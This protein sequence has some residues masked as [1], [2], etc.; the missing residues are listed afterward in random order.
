MAQG[1]KKKY[2]LKK[3]VGWLHLVLGL[4]SGLIIVLL[5]VTGCILAF[6][7]E[8]RSVTQ[9]A[10]YTTP[11]NQPVLP[12]SVLKANAKKVLDGPLANG[13]ESPGEGKSAVVS[14]YDAD[15]FYRVALDP[16]T[17]AVKEKR[18]MNR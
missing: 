8:I 2:G 15:H 16:Y 11:T 1:A 5:G 4:S 3:I 10:F 9:P 12:P 17:G 13:I 7:H 14:Y 18:N 6:E